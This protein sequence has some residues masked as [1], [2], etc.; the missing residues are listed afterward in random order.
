M[1]DLIEFIQNNTSSFDLIIKGTKNRS[2]I[3]E[4]SLV[5]SFKH[6]A[7]FKTICLILVFFAIQTYTVIIN[8]R[9]L[10]R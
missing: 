3:K 1:S 9:Q 7:M 6:V 5:S 8:T 2:N 4:A 10:V